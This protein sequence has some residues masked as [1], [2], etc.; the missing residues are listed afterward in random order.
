[1]FLFAHPQCSGSEYLVSYI[2]ATVDRPIQQS[3]SS[4]RTG[5]GLEQRRRGRSC[6]ASWT[7]QKRIAHTSSHEYAGIRWRNPSITSKN[8]KSLRE[9][10][11]L[12]PARV[13]SFSAVRQYVLKLSHHKPCR[14]RYPCKPRFISS[15]NWF[16]S[17]RLAEVCVRRRGRRIL[18]HQITWPREP[19]IREDLSATSN[20]GPG[21]AQTHTLPTTLNK[22]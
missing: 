16:Q 5:S 7:S 9:S 20:P 12:Q 4:L 21:H 2:R 6:R 14:E 17:L 10:G 18:L 15:W 22:Q 11:S 13:Q 19:A 8:A 1:M 3:R